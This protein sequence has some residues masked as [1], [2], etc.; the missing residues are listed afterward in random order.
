MPRC[1]YEYWRKLQSRFSFLTASQEYATIS[2]LTYQRKSL[3]LLRTK[4]GLSHTKCNMQGQGRGVPASPP[5]A[6]GQPVRAIAGSPSTSAWLYGRYKSRNLQLCE[7]DGK[8]RRENRSAIVRL[9]NRA[10][11]CAPYSP[12]TRARTP[13]AGIQEGLTLHFQFPSD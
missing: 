7:V 4:L 8:E 2:S 5:L 11:K 13:P 9:E 12:L 6:T 1:K 10:N 3:C